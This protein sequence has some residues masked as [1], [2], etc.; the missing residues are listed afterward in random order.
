MI[1]LLVN[2]AP[3]L[4]IATKEFTNELGPVT[5][6]MTVIRLKNGRLLLH[7]PVPID[8]DLRAAVE[9]HGRP[10][11]L[12][13]PNAFHHQFVSEWASAFPGTKTF[14][15]PSLVAKRDDLKFDEVLDGVNAPSWA[16]EVDYLPI[17]GI[18]SYDEVVFFH[19]PSRTLV[20]SDI[21]F[22]YTPAQAASDP[23][24]ATGLGPHDRIRAA[25]TDHQALTESI[26]QVLRWPFDRVILS[27][28]QIV[29]TDGHA[30]FRAGFAFLN[31]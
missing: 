5:S 21:S 27:H 12:I 23:G 2:L 29:E 31:V 9:Q 7:S 14:C 22:N 19:R 4:W 1:T 13:A 10:E 3:D 17:N 24:A 11:A 18:P 30:H 28:G 6:R 20:L 26:E 25:I 8:H 15:V 16:G